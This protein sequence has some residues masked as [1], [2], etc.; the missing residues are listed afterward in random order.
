MKH[1]AKILIGF[2]TIFIVLSIFTGG[3]QNVLMLCFF[4]VIC[5]AGVGLIPL[6]GVSYA[7]GSVIYL[8][9]NLDKK[10]L[11]ESAIS[12]SSETITIPNDKLAILDYIRKARARG[13]ADAQIELTLKQNG[14]DPKIIEDTIKI[15]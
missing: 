12:S 4:L 2:F 10:L 8:F 5:T 15:S 6:V 7:I 11:Q 14:W 13:Q 9:L 1:L 3:P